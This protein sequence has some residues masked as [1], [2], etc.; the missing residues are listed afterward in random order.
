VATLDAVATAA[1]GLLA[2]GGTAV[3]S[4]IVGALRSRGR[5]RAA[6][7]SE[8][9]S[10]AKEV[11]TILRTELREQ[12]ERHRSEMSRLRE[13]LAAAEAQ[14]L[15]AQAEVTELKRA[16]ALSGGAPPA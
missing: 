5:D 8:I 11:V 3:L 6:E 15:A 12:E 10:G 4:Q 13:R 9:V 2:A 16:L 14:A 7:D 1:T